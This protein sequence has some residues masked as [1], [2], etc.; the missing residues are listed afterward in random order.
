MG[1]PGSSPSGFCAHTRYSP[2]V[3]ILECFIALPFLNR[4]YLSHIIVKKSYPTKMH[5]DGPIF[6]QKLVLADQ[7]EYWFG[8]LF[9]MMDHIL[10]T[11]HGQLDAS[12]FNI[13]QQYRFLARGI[14]YNMLV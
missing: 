4:G 8:E 13:L 10:L 14:L 12:Y 6:I 2:E 3:R 9:F 1:S 11:P 7:H 5:V